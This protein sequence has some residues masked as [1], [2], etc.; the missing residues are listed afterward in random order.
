MMTTA[1]SYL[2]STLRFR[3]S[4]NPIEN[5]LKEHQGCWLV[6]EP[7]SWRLGGAKTLPLENTIAPGNAIV[8]SPT[9]STEDALALA[10]QLRAGQRQ[11]TLGRGDHCDIIINE[12]TLS[13]LHLVFMC[14]EKHWTVRDAASKNGSF[15]N[16][17]PLVP[18][19]PCF[20]QGG[21]VLTAGKALFTFLEPSGMH[22]RLQQD[23]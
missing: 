11:L 1:R 15:V 19:R 8:V 4:H 3:F 20:L 9:A 14:T 6:W 22:Q 2:L 23:F 10:L 16:K 13:Q 17:H 12:A 7:G 5:L 18:G 21:D